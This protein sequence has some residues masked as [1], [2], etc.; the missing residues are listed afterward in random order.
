MEVHNIFVNMVSISLC[1]SC[2]TLYTKLK[3]LKCMSWTACIFC[4]W[5]ICVLC[6]ID[7]LPEVEHLEI[8]SAEEKLIEDLGSYD[9]VSKGVK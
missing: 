9:E 3:N 8:N 7:L 1:K 4:V 5:G 6:I 2:V